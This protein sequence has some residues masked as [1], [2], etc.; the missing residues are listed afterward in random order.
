MGGIEFR[1]I[2]IVDKDTETGTKEYNLQFKQIGLRS[3]GEVVLTHR[4]NG[5]YNAITLIKIKLD[6]KV[7]D[8]F[9]SDFKNLLEKY[10]QEIIPKL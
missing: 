1:K 4:E 7:I 9:C 8:K 10:N 6:E 2:E 3:F 5:F